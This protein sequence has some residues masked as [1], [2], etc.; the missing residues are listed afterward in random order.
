MDVKKYV[1][2]LLENYNDSRKK[3]S[4]LT[5]EL[6]HPVV[7]SEDNLI[8]SLSIPSPSGGGV[9]SGTV[10]DK[11]SSTALNYRNVA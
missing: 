2:S 10:S 5:Y 1:M 4:I 9:P 6:E 11:T 8:Q 3:I 7:I